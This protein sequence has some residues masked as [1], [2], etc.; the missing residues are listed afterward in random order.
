MNTV[1]TERNNMMHSNDKK[2]KDKNLA[3]EMA[4]L[5]AQNE[6]KDLTHLCEEV[7]ADECNDHACNMKMKMMKTTMQMKRQW[8][9]VMKKT[10]QTMQT[11][12]GNRI[13][14][15]NM[16]ITKQEWQQQTDATSCH[17]TQI[18][19]SASMGH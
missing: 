15:M 9:N 13:W 3:R 18:K 7:P 16:R 8:R 19:A 2:E 17:S 11:K 4:K 1:K 12:K 10:K 14:K 6:S 5:A